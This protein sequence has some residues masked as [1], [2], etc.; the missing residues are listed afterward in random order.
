MLVVAGPPGSGKTTYFPVTAFGVDSFNVDDRCAQ[1]LGSYRAISPDVRRAV[2]QECERFVRDHIDRRLSFAVETTL[3]TT[4]AVEQ[5]KLARNHGFS[6]HLRFIATDSVAENV[7][8]VLQRAQSGGH[9]ASERD[10]RVI[11]AASIANLGRA[12]GVFQRIRVYDSTARWTTPRLIATARDGRLTRH[13]ASPEW[14]E[15]VLSAPGP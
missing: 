6:T 11:C 14:L 5:A 15:R 13:G 7:S 8:R 12:I 2:A 1:I 9:A 3:R 4:A 10:I